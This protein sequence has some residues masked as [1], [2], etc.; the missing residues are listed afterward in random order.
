MKFDSDHRIVSNYIYRQLSRVLR[1]H[2]LFRRC[3]PL[4]LAMLDKI[5]KVTLLVVLMSTRR[6][7][8]WWARPSGMSC[9]RG[10][11][12]RYWIYLGFVWFQ[13]PSKKTLPNISY[14][15]KFF[16]FAVLSSNKLANPTEGYEKWPRELQ[17]DL[18]DVP[19]LTLQKLLHFSPR[20]AAK[21]WALQRRMASK[22][23]LS[24]IWGIRTFRASRLLPI[25]HRMLLE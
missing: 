24:W 15:F 18:R 17:A 25:T 13:M 6:P 2:L 23:S 7:S 5:L 21:S 1:N 9:R 20:W 16:D 4:L 8:R 22:A 14:T 3:S 12:T 19:V 11:P 10:H